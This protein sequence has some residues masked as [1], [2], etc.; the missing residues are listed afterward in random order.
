ML[1]LHLLYKVETKYTIG[2][3]TIHFATD[4]CTYTMCS[5]L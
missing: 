5:D 2:P 1:T 3:V 4:E